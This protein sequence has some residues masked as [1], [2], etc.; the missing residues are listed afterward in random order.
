MTAEFV[1]ISSLCV[2]TMVNNVP[3]TARYGFSRILGLGHILWVPL[4]VF[5][6]VRLGS[7]P[8]DDAFG[9]WI[10]VLLL[11]NGIS[12]VIDTKDVVRYLGGDRKETVSG[13]KE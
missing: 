2:S 10:R 9:I 11:L 5:L 1:L 3:L 6:F 12:L 4:V 8:A 13:S 7:I